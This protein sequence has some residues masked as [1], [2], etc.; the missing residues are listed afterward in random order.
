M[1]A[2]TL[3]SKYRKNEDLIMSPGEIKSLYFYGITIQDR[4]GKEMEDDVWRHYILAAQ[5]EI[6][7]V[8]GIKLK[9][10]IIT[11]NLDFYADEWRQ[12]NYIQTTYPVVKPFKLTGFLGTVKQLE[13]PSDWLTSRRTSDGETYYRRIFTVPVQS[14]QITIEGV[15]MMYSGVL[16]S[17]GMNGWNTIPNYWT[18]EYCTGFSVIPEDLMDV[19]GK[20]AAIGPF[21][22][23]G[24]IALGQ[25]ALA[26]YSLSLDGLSQSV[27]TTNSATN[28]AFGARIIQY[29]KEIKDS[30]QKLKNYYRG[31]GM[32]SM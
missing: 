22:I 13:Y 28:A 30:L 10:Q 8:L 6:E 3:E 2:L 5:R 12:W 19:V 1:P 16:P 14:G 9:K 31:I 11:E 25:A 23:A 32:A 4:S 7:K 15:S 17:L 29:N 18:V 21:N 20:L 27:G 24:D 26:N